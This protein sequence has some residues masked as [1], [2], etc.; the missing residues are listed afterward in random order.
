MLRWQPFALLFGIAA[1]GSLIAT[2]IMWPRRRLTPAAAAM[3][4]AMAGLAWWSATKCLSVLATDLEVK[5]AFETAIYPGVCACVAGFFCYAKGMADRAWTLSRSAALLLAIEPAFAIVTAATNTWHREFYAGAALSGSPPLLAPQPGPA[6][7]VHTIYSYALLAWAMFALVRACLQA[8]RSYRGHFVW[9]LVAVVPPVIGNI[10]TVSYMP[11]GKTVGLT[12]VFFCI[13]AGACCWALLREALPELVPVA[14]RQI[15]ETI[16]DAVI[17]IDRSSRVLD[18]NPAADRLL[19]RLQPDAPP[20]ILGMQARDVLSIDRALSAGS[21]AEYTL[22]AADGQRFDL[23][24]RHS[25]LSD[26]ANKVIGWVLVVH[27]VTERNRQRHELRATNDELREQLLA[28]ERLRAELAE[29]ASRDSLTGLHNRRY[30][31]GALDREVAL[32]AAER[33]P[34]SVVMIDI[35][36][37][38]G[39]NDRFGHVAGDEV[40]ATTAQRITALIQDGESAV[41]YGGEEF[42]LVLPGCTAEQARQRAETMREVCVSSSFII[43]GQPVTVTI[44]AG[45]AE[46]LGSES[47]AALIEAADQALYV[48]KSLGRNRIETA[49]VTTSSVQ[50]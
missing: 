8:P 17:V 4:V 2:A 9:P 40:I 43:G 10:I 34:L 22:T 45:V 26:R 42:F 16:S 12:P 50:K 48:A 13:S 37:F 14:G 44:S 33:R 27:D 15:L 23:N 46:Y 35:D 1:F 7:W 49:R 21:D 38:K 30:L 36:H 29:Q 28:V 31:I 3:T 11:Q 39:I 32:A 25:A 18:L 24:V 19:R 5:L 47:P 6:F 20:S 41:R